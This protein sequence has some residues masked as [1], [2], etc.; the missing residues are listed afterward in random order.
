MIATGLGFA[1]VTPFWGILLVAVV[2][3]LNPTSGDVS[4]FLPTEQA[5]LATEVQRRGPAAHLRHVQPRRRGRRRRR[6]ARSRPTRAAARTR[7]A[8]AWTRRSG[9]RSGSTR[10][11]AS[12]SSLLYRRPPTRPPPTDV[13]GRGRACSAT[14]RRTVLELAALF[15]LDSAGGGFVVTSL[16]VLWLHLRFDLSAG[17]TGAPVLRG[18]P[19]RRLL[20]TAR[21]PAGDRGS[22]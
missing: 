4:V 14:S 3:T 11:P 6:R 15:S 21:R 8:G 18:R 17:A 2:G 9:S 1:L 19:A 10:S 7:S 13:D 20:A 12:P 16:L 22:G 5:L